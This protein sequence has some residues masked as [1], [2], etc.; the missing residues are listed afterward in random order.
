[1]C[2]HDPGNPEVPDW[3]CL[4]SNTSILDPSMDLEPDRPMPGSHQD[5]GKGQAAVEHAEQLVH[6]FN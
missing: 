2:E 1:M 3:T 5:P 4:Y 6:R